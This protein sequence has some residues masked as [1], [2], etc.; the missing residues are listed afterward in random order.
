[1][2][3]RNLNTFN[4]LILNINEIFR[5]IFNTAIIIKWQYVNEKKRNKNMAKK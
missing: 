2:F 5:P 3:L 4:L 1:M